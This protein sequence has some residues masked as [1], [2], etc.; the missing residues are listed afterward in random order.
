[1][2]ITPITTWKSN[3]L[4]KKSLI[5]QDHKINQETTFVTYHWC[6]FYHS[7]H[8]HTCK[9]LMWLCIVECSTQAGWV[10]LRCSSR[11]A[12]M[13]L[14]YETSC[15]S[16]YAKY[17]HNRSY[18]IEPYSH[19]DTPWW[20]AVLSPWTLCQTSCCSLWFVYCHG[21]PCHD[22]GWISCQKARCQI[23]LPVS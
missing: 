18:R 10:Y 5:Y 23:W 13:D 8:I 9:F 6:C 17:Y 20:V 11:W 21:T 7:A 19:T 3:N 1:M 14:M 15:F 2:S 12:T 16:Y 22:Q 4:Q